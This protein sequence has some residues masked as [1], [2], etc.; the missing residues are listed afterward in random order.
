LIVR[1][2][3]TARASPCMLQGAAQR[4]GGGWADRLHGVVRHQP[5]RQ[6]DALN[7]QAPWASCFVGMVNYTWSCSSDER[8]V[9]LFFGICVKKKK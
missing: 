3:L 1:E 5:D 4:R 2:A 8:L 6:G 9:L 7:S